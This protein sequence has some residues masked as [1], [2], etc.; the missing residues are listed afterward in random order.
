MDPDSIAC[1]AVLA[2]TGNF[3]HAARRCGLS[4]P[5]L[6]RLIH[7]LEEESSAPLFERQRNDIRLTLE[8]MRLLGA[9]RSGAT[10]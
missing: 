3:T 4:Q 9:C 7:R 5:A 10:T 8:G 6:T 2:E 1:F